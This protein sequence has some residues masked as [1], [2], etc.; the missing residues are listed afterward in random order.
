MTTKPVFFDASGRRSARM[1]LAGRLAAIATALV[2]AVF[3]ASL[4]IEPHIA[5]PN[6][7]G[8]LSAVRAAELER[9]AADPFLLKAA[10]RL[11]AEVRS[12]RAALPRVWKQNGSSWGQSPHPAAVLQPRPARP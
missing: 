2:A 10:A 12:K 9:R 3:I 1:S 7:P 5:S 6:L 8:H 11:A 4:L